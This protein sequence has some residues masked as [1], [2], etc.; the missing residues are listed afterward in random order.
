VLSVESQSTFRRSISLPSGEST[1]KA[2]KLPASRYWYGITSILLERKTFTSDPDDGDG[3]GS[4][5]VD[6]F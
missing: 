6:N 1:N 5:N 3:D 2:S 4:R